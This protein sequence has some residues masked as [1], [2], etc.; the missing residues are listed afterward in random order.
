MKRKI[1]KAGG[2]HLFGRWSLIQYLFFRQRP[3]RCVGMV[4][5]PPAENDTVTVKRESG[6]TGLTGLPQ[7]Y[8]TQREAPQGTAVKGFSIWGPGSL[9]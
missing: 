6:G 2:K 5:R 8:Q 1:D 9:R 7:S 3:D 4:L